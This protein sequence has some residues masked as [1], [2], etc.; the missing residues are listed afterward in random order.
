MSKRIVPYICVQEETSNELI[1]I[2]TDYENNGTDE[3]LF[4]NAMEGDVV[5]EEFLMAMK[6]VIKSTDL[7]VVVGIRVKR[8]EDVKKAFYTGAKAVVIR[9]AELENKEIIKESIQRFGVEQIMIELPEEILKT[10]ISLLHEYGVVYVICNKHDEYTLNYVK[11]YK[12]NV[13]ALSKEDAITD[14]CEALQDT[15][16]VAVVTRKVPAFSMISYKQELKDK[17]IDTNTFESKLSF[18]E[19]KLDSHGLIPVIVQDYKTN[20]VLML[21]YMNRESF[22][23]TIRTG[24]MTYYSRS[25]QEL[26]IKGETSGHY[27]YVKQLSLDCDKDTVLAKVRQVGAACH[28]GSRSCFYTELMKKDYDNTNPFSVFEDVYD[29]IM[30]RK[31]HPKEGSYTNYLFDK[32]IDKILKKCGEEATEIIIA[33]KNPEPEEL[34]YEIADF[35]YHCMVLMAERGVDWKDI[36]KELSHRR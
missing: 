19:F 3:I 16:V 32:G 17:G 36:T 26:W 12:M 15:N 14:I 33:A 23:T 1:D 28:T 8:F 25:R 7:P 27:Q 35:L 10:D 6:A 2:A 11:E 5:Q 30:D 20:E 21:A 4:S 18:D 22:N 34:K 9:Y 13:Y 31:E 24:R 29:I